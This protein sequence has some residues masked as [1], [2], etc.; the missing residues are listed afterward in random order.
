MQSHKYE[1]NKE[2]GAK[3]A[4]VFGWVIAS[5]TVSFLIT[6]LPQLNLGDMAFLIPIV[7]MVLVTVR[8][9]IKGNS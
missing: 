7:N 5:T 2:D 1:L 9:F 8:K 4:K 6:L 3:I